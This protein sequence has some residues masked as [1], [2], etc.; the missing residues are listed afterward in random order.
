MARILVVDDDVAVR[1]MVRRM[2]ERAGHSVID[3]ANGAEALTLCRLTRPELVVTNIVMPEKEGLE[4][5]RE[6][7]A[8]QPDLPVIA[9]SGGGQAARGAYLDMARAFGAIGTLTKPF[10][11]TTLLRAVEHALVPRPSGGPA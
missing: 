2:L 6:L 3:A 5:I 7:R 8:E 9:M 10:D 11:R 1:E 4:L